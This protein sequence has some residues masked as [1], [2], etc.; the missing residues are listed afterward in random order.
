MSTRWG[1]RSSQKNDGEQASQLEPYFDGVLSEQCNQYSECADFEPYL[2]A[3]KPVINAE[4]K[5]KT[6]RFCAADEA[7]GI[8]G[9]R[10]NLALNGKRFDPAGRGPACQPSAAASRSAARRSIALRVARRAPDVG[11]Q[12]RPG[13]RQQPRR[14]SGL[15]RVDIEAGGQQ[16]PGLECLGEGLFIDDGAAGRVHEHGPPRIRASRRRSIRPRSSPSAER[17]G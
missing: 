15:V 12:H 6:R 5:L 17:G 9:A 2:R 10:F 8:I 7:A 11:Q 1:W 13:R 14:T 4:Y 3:G 16:V